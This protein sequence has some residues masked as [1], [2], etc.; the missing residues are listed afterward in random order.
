MGLQLDLAGRRVLVLGASSGIGRAV[1]ELAAAAGARLALAARR[2]DR[3]AALAAALAAAGGEAHPITCDVARDADC[4]E[5]VA[6]AAAALG[7]LD[8]LVYAPGLSPLVLL[9]EASQERWRDVLDVNLIGAS[10]VT[11]AALPHLRA[12]QGRALYVGSYAARQTLPGI[13]LYSVSKLA[14]S[15]LVAA[16]RMEHPDVDFIHITLGNTSDTE[17]AAG[18]D[19]Q[20]SARVIQGWLERGLFPAP[21]MMP[22]RSAA[23]AIVA[24]LATRA[25][26]DEVGVMPR[27]RDG[28]V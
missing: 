9:S 3:L 10:L 26:L 27:L 24:A 15:G 23:E 20:Q 12:S 6:A 21:R 17:F 13:A 18:W 4:R 22:L 7:G 14:L 1:A 25:F 19:P 28:A 16:W 11:A 5:V 2:Q 8:A